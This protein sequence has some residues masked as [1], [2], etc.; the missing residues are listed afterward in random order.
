MNFIFFIHFSDRCVH[1]PSLRENKAKDLFENYPEDFIKFT[2]RQI[3]K[4]YPHGTRTSSSNLKT[5]PFWSVGAQV[6]ELTA[7]ASINNLA[8]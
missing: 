3:S 6:G 2:R 5:Y 8:R 1:F 7:K 4:I